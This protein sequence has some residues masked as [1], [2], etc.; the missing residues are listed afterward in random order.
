MKR[1]YF[2]T[3]ILAAALFLVVVPQS[4]TDL[5]EELFDS[6][7][8]DNFFQTDDE[9]QA[10]FAEAY[11]RLRSFANHNNYFSIQEVSSDEV[12]I[13]QRG[14][15]WFDGGL[16]L[17]VHRHEQNPNEGVVNNVWNFAY[18]GSSDDGVRVAN[19]AKQ[20]TGWSQKVNEQRDRPSGF[21]VVLPCE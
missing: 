14:G 15:D 11:A 6:V 8:Q 17:R 12:M 5:E 9:L 19:L 7:G 16:W 13:P 20:I 21:R 4:C 3:K 1:L 18:G 2:L 10:G